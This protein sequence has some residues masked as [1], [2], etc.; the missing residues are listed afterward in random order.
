M[1]KVEIYSTSTCPYCKMEKQY[2]TEKGIRFTNYDVAV[3]DTKAD[4]MIKKSGQMGVPVTIISNGEEK[5]IVGFDR[6][7]LTESLEIEG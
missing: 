2:L 1:K 4:E 6:N 7:K 5:V 3:D